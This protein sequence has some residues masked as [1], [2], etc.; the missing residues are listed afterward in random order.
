MGPRGNGGSRR[1][2]RNRPNRDRGSDGSSGNQV[3]AHPDRIPS[4][5]EKRS[6]AGLGHR[7]GVVSMLATN[8]GPDAAGR[9]ALRVLMQRLPD[10]TVIDGGYLEP[11]NTSEPPTLRSVLVVEGS[12]MRAIRVP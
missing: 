10:V 2:R 8:S 11:F 1:A 6:R 4:I 7:P 9:A 5:L 3:D 12:G